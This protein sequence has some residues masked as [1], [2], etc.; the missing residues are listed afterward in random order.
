M[1]NKSHSPSLEKKCCEANKSGFNCRHYMKKLLST[2]P[3][4][5]WEKVEK[6]LEELNAE[7]GYHMTD[8]GDR[9]WEVLKS[10]IRESLENARREERERLAEIIEKKE[11]EWGTI[12]EK[13]DTFFMKG[14]NKEGYTLDQ[15]SEDA[16]RYAIKAE[17][18]FEIF[19]I[20]RESK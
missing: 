14:E 2:S 1:N 13:A 6:E 5:D 4:S 15:A 9:R 11:K 17:T 7:H 19:T 8:M 3:T 16:S 20:L 18:A 10:F 12:G